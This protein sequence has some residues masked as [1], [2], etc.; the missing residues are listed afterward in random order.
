MW[1]GI[2][3][4]TGW[5]GFLILV[6][7]KSS[8]NWSNSRRSLRPRRG[9]GAESCWSG[10]LSTGTGGRLRCEGPRA[11]TAAPSGPCKHSHVPTEIITN[12]DPHQPCSRSS[13]R[14]LL[15]LAVLTLRGLLDIKQSGEAEH[16][17]LWCSTRA[18]R[19]Q[20]IS[21]EKLVHTAGK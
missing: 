10:T 2:S 3:S 13:P 15:L 6:L 8:F 12:T 9:T 5:K 19:L 1:R 14:A 18:L 17:Q 20:E 7:T 4:T 21:Q 16:L 11:A